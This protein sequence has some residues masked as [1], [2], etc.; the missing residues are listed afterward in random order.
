MYNL[1]VHPEP[2]K[3]DPRDLLK[4]R[5]CDIVSKKGSKGLQTRYVIGFTRLRPFLKSTYNVRFNELNFLTCRSKNNNFI[6]S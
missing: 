6:N 5:I 2:G 1:H 4:A 3:R